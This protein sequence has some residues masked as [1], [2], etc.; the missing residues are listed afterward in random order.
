M[1]KRQD[2]G[3]RS[4]L[5]EAFPILSG[6]SPRS[7]EP[8]LSQ[9]V[10]RSLPPG[11]I[12]VRAGRECSY[13]PL[14]LTGTL[15]IYKANEA[16]RE[17]TLYRIEPGESCILTATC[18]LSGGIFPAIAEAEVATEVLLIPARLFARLV[19]EDADW[20]RFVFGLYSRRLDDVL[21]LVEEVAFQHVDM[22]IASHLLAR[23]SKSGSVVRQTHARIAS[24]LGTS[25]E[26]V[27]RILKDFEAQGLVATRRGAID[28]LRP[29]EL[30]KKTA[31]LPVL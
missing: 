10:H 28:I 13:L 25:R 16:G 12:L 27:T 29:Q 21:A 15:R 22:R 23:A 19:E 17:F 9:S 3:S 6:L 7:R 5:L 18:I 1:G 14:V 2:I 30:E 26:V 20:R 11:E 8:L 4:G 24:E 31:I